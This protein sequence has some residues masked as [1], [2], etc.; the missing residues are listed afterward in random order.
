MWRIGDAAI[1]V[2]AGLGAA[3]LAGAAVGT[4]DPSTLQVFGLVVPAQTLTTVA[5][6][7]ALGRGREGDL[8]ESLGLAYR[9]VDLMGLIHG[10]AIQLGMG[11]V[12]LLVTEVLDIDFTTQ[13]VVQEA[14]SAVGGLEWVLVIVGAGI[15]A[16]ISEELAFR[17]VLLQALLRRLGPSVAVMASSAA[18]ALLHLVDPNAWLL[19][20]LLF[21]MGIVLG[22]V[23]VRYGR[24]SMAVFTHISFNTIS[25]V[26]LLLSGGMEGR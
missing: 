21:L 10:F 12:L 18:W 17:G 11:M 14:E 3:I 23:T 1:A 19:V 9:H 25:V 2:L 26:T 16:P 8:R 15:L 13:Q 4:Q 7:Y 24:I 6:I 5:V 22:A 20:P